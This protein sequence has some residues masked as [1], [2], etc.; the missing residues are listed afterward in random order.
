[1]NIFF[2]LR[3]GLSIV[4]ASARC[5]SAPSGTTVQVHGCTHNGFEGSRSG[6]DWQD[7]PLPDFSLGNSRAK[8]A[9]EWFAKV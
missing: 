1:M 9:Q 2:V 7:L 8:E 4:L 3:K 5:L 6:L